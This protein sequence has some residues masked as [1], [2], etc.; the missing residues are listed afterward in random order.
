MTQKLTL[1]QNLASV[2]FL[3]RSD[4]DQYCCSK[5][6][7]DILVHFQS[8]EAFATDLHGGLVSTRPQR[9]VSDSGLDVPHRQAYSL[10]QS[11]HNDVLI[12][13]RS[14]HAALV[15]RDQTDT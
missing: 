9:G 2:F 15:W 6:G 4:V 3:L 7:A 1:G 12:V 5:M 10:G 13:A 14:D 11:E 8:N